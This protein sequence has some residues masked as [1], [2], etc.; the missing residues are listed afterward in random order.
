MRKTFDLYKD[1][2][3]NDPYELDKFIGDIIEVLVDAECEHPE[4]EEGA[5][6]FTYAQIRDLMQAHY[7]KAY[8]PSDRHLER[9]PTQREVNFALEVLLSETDPHEQVI[10]EEGGL[11]YAISEKEKEDR[12]NADHTAGYKLDKVSAG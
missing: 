8:D 1:L 4:E 9:K 5:H 7:D 2:D 10:R 11:I 12:A 3:L 6:P